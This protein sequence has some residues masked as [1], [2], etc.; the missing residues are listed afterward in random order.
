MLCSGATRLLVLSSCFIIR[1]SFAM[2]INNITPIWFALYLS[3]LLLRYLTWI[4]CPTDISRRIHRWVTFTPR[5]N[6][7]ALV[8]TKCLTFVS[9]TRYELIKVLM[10]NA[11]TR[12]L[13]LIS[14][15]S[16]GNIYPSTY[17]PKK[18]VVWAT[19]F[20]NLLSLLKMHKRDTINTVS[21]SSLWRFK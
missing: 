4:G 20:E 8:S 17:K 7:T 13:I 1:Q 9:Y 2:R 10:P 19:F 5:A 14:A 3:R 12:I 11:Y 16:R 6:T 15:F 21:L 18:H